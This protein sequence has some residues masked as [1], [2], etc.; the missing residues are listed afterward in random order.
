MKSAKYIIL[1]IL[2]ILSSGCISSKYALVQNNINN[3]EWDQAEKI[4][5]E[6]LQ[7]DSTAGTAY[8]YLGLIFSHRGNDNS[9]LEMF[10]K[11]MKYQPTFESSVEIAQI[12][13]NHNRLFSA[14]AYLDS[15]K[16]L[17][18]TSEEI[19][20]LNIKVQALL[21]SSEKAFKVGKDFYRENNFYR[22]E[23]KFQQA[24]NI[25]IKQDN[26]GA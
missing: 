26:A 5:N 2:I 16:M 13:F 10:K 14:K 3:G 8:H 9:A 15:A 22:A 7:K 12:Y 23:Q 6:I 1:L 17:N 21:S 11:S 20:A 18:P 4:C 19:K 25:N 24:L